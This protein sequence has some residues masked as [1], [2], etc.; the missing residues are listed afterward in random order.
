[1]IKVLWLDHDREIDEDRLD[2]LADLIKTLPPNSFLLITFSAQPSKYGKAPE[3]P[4]RIRNLYG[5]AAPEP[6]TARDCKDDA[7]CARVLARATQD[8]LLSKA[9]QSARPG[10]Y[11]PAVNLTYKDSVPMVTVGGVLPSEENHGSVQAVV[12][13][14]DWPGW[15]D[16][17]IDAPPLTT[18]E[19]MALQS[20][21]PRKNKLT[22]E[23]VQKIGFDLEEAHLTSYA[24]HYL[25]YPQFA[26][27]AR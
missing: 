9:L 1:V 22:R 5:D 2:E 24:D 3:R 19:V 12:E 21:L 23:D 26:Q 16:R 13:S 7:P 15:V 8:L 18:K 11:V 27:V 10:S 17:M 14:A 20:M 25:R 6:L 4:D